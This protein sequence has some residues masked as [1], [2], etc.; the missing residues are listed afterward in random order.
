MLKRLISYILIVG[1]A[2]PALRDWD[3]LLSGNHKEIHCDEGIPNHFHQ[4]EF[5]C[6]FHKFH[7]TIALENLNWNYDFPVFHFFKSATPKFQYLF[8]RSSIDLT[9]LRGPPT[10]AFL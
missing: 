10:P 8:S 4:S 9:Y 1:L 3:H 2:L 5:D 6:D 7:F